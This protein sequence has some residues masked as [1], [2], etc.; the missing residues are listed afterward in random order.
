MWGLAEDLPEP[1]KRTHA[2]IVAAA[3]VTEASDLPW[4]HKQH[5]RRSSGVDGECPLALVPLFNL[6]W[7]VCMDFMHIVKVLL[8]G[9]LIA[10]LKSKR[11]LQPP[12]VKINA[13]ENREESP[14]SYN[15]SFADLTVC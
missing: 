11:S 8:V 10:L 3:A 1:V 14:L 6:V 13:A 12:Q 15:R 9:H 2:S 7:E 4:E 5:P